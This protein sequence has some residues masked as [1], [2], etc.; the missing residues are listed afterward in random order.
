MHLYTDQVLI[1]SLIRQYYNHLRKVLLWVYHLFLYLSNVFCAFFDCT[2]FL[3]SQPF[4]NTLPFKSLGSVRLHV[5]IYSNRKQFISI[6]TIFHNI[7]VFTVFW[8]NKCSLIEHKRCLWQKKIKNTGPKLLNSSVYY[9]NLRL[10]SFPIL[11]QKKLWP[12]YNC[13]IIYTTIIVFAVV[14]KDHLNLN[15]LLFCDR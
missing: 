13:G 12:T 5:N 2:I 7:T 1:S 3:F 4:Q 6:L 15:S 11:L 9:Y 10:K 8:L 14:F